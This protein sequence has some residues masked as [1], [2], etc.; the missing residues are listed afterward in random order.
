MSA[1]LLDGTEV[2]YVVMEM[3]DVPDVE[4][5]AGESD[6]EDEGVLADGKVVVVG[7]MVEA[8]EAADEDTGKVLVLVASFCSIDVKVTKASG[9]GAAQVSLL[10]VE[11]CTPVVGSLLQQAQRPVV[12]LYTMSG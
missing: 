7:E 5:A 2:E 12:A 1:A 8:K 10:A 4:M 6:T 11:Q 3:G 9:A